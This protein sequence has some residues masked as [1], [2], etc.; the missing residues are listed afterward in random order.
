MHAH[1]TLAATH[2]HHHG[3]NGKKADDRDAHAISDC[4]PSISVFVGD[5]RDWRGVVACGQ[6]QH[7][8]TLIGEVGHRR[9]GCSKCKILY[10]Y[11]PAFES[12]TLPISDSHRRPLKEAERLQVN[13]ILERRHLSDLCDAQDY[14]MIDAAADDIQLRRASW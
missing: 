14:M 12:L 3:V 13:G 2:S 4:Y 10:N 9:V 7:T 8:G 1:R 6:A 11:L 5:H